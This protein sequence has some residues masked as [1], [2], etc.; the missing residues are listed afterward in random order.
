M[1]RV[2]RVVRA[3]ITPE[4]NLTALAIC[5]GVYD[6]PRAALI[7]AAVMGVELS[8]VAIFLA[9]DASRLELD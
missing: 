7:S 1:L 8:T 3:K 4:M 9:L 2:I 5:S 6:S